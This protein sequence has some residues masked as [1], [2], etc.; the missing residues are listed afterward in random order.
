MEIIIYGIGWILATLISLILITRLTKMYGYVT[1]VALFSGLYVISSILA[2]KIIILFGFNVPAGTILFSITFLL[3]DM[4]SEFFVKEKARQAV[5]LGLISQIFLVLSLWV[6]IEWPYPDYWQNQEAFE[7][8]L[9]STWRIVIGSFVAFLISQNHDIWAFHLW[10][11]KF[12]NKHL[13]F[14]NNASTVVSQFL[15]S[16][17]FT[18]I[19]FWGMLPVW[20]IILG[21]FGVKVIIAIIDTPFLYLS[22]YIYNKE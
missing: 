1:I 17:A 6:V 11:K 3:T 22:R 15:D 18:Y 19:A 7:T 8:S 5:W 21:T 16:V 2:N 10:K 20:P 4:L 13:W 14:R 12:G 9:S